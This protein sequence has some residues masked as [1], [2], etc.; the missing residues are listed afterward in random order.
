[1]SADLLKLTCVRFVFFILPYN[2]SN[3]LRHCVIVF[4]S[5]YRHDRH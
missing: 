2:I 1:M 4:L 5:V 3:N